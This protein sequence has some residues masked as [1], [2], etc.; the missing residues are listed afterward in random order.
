M[1][2]WIAKAV[3]L[4]ATLVMIAIRA[5]HGRRSRAVKTVRTCKGPR[6]V[7]LLLLAWI[8]FLAPLIWVASPAFRFAEYPLR[9]LPLVAGIACLVV[10]LWYF[11]RS[12]ADLGAYWSVTLEVR[13]SHR[14][15]T[16]G[17]YRRIRHPMYA[18]LFLYSIGQLLTVPNWIAGPSYLVSF[19]ILFA[20]RFKAEEEMM[21][22]AFGAEYA[23]YMATTQ[24][25][26]R[27]IW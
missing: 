20:F 22:D 6:E 11:Y 21:L 1:N 12:H 19:G 16:N 24:R 8:G 15:I 9:V 7:V 4:A 2:P 27:G 5:P 17:V 18:A 3:I 13:E 10:A 25:L 23:S 26:V 14:L